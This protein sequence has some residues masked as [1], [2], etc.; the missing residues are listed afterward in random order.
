MFFRSYLDLHNR[1][2]LPQVNPQLIPTDSIIICNPSPGH[3]THPEPLCQ[4]VRQ[5]YYTPIFTP[6]MGRQVLGLFE[7]QLLLYVLGAKVGDF[8]SHRKTMILFSF[9][10]YHNCI[11]WKWPGLAAALPTWCPVLKECIN[12]SGWHLCVGCSFVYKRPSGIF[13]HLIQCPV[14]G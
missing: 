9:Q 11:Q 5:N 12:L 7:D 14:G 10:R 8:V 3:A 2:C 1:E 13:P 6:R 4:P